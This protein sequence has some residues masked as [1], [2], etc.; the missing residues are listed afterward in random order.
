MPDNIIEFPKTKKSREVILES[1]I[2][3]VEEAISFLLKTSE[4][5]I[6][7]GNI[8]KTEAS[9]SDKLLLEAIAKLRTCRFD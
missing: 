1:D 3:T 7:I 8:G 9:L 5:Q 2:T 6:A 4:E